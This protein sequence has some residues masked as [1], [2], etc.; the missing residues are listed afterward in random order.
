M[1]SFWRPRPPFSFKYSYLPFEFLTIHVISTSSSSFDS[2]DA[3]DFFNRTISPHHGSSGSPE[4][5]SMDMPGAKCSSSIF[6]VTTSSSSVSFFFFSFFWTLFAFFVEIFGSFGF[7]FFFFFV[8]VVVCFLSLL[9]LPS[10]FPM[11]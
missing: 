3:S 2:I 7:F 4:S 6:P 8:V 9:L 1:T 11:F 10:C 5:I